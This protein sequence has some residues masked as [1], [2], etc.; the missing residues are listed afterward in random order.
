[1]FGKQIEK[2]FA[3]ETTLAAMFVVSVAMIKDTSEITTTTG[4]LNLKAKQRDPR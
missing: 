1:M 2:S 4:L 3:G